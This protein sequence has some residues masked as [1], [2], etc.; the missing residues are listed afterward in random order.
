[1]L[2]W[3]FDRLPKGRGG[4]EVR[5]SVRARYDAAT[6]SEDNRRHWAHA[7]GLSAN[8]ANSPEVRRVLRNRARYETANNSYARG[9]VLTL[10][11]DVVGTGPRLQ[12]LTEDGEAN[13]R[14]EQA[15]MTWSKAIRLA[16]KLRTMRSARATDGEAFAILINNPAL[17]T[18]IQLD[19]RLVEAE[20]VATPDLVRPT[21]QAID[22]IEFDAAG[23]PTAY[24]VL[25]HHPGDGAAALQRDYDRIPAAAVLHWFRVDR[26]GQARGIPDIMP[27][28]PLFAQLRRFTLAVLAAAETAADFAG[29]LYT[30]APANGEADAAEPFEPIELEK[31]ALLTMPGG[32]KMSQM[33]AEQPATTYAEFKHELLNEIARCL[34]M[35]YN[36]AAANSSGYNYASGRLDHQT[37]FKAIRVEQSHLEGVVLDRLLAAWFDEAALLPDLLPAG[38]GP[39]AEWP[40]QWFWD[41]HEHV[42]PNPRL[43]Q[44]GNTRGGLQDRQAAPDGSHRRDA[45][46]PVRGQAGRVRRDRGRLQ[47]GAR[48]GA[49]VPASCEGRRSGDAGAVR[50]RGDR[51]GLGAGPCGPRRVDRRGEGPASRKGREAAHEGTCAGLCQRR[52]PAPERAGRDRRTMAES[53]RAHG[54][55]ALGEQ[56]RLEVRLT[57]RRSPVPRRSGTFGAGPFFSFPRTSWTTSWN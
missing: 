23:N 38:L 18:P 31:R 46:T 45:R 47:D 40:H 52:R 37:Y 4:R 43:C 35:P 34:N 28:L 49:E 50:A 16:E 27:A 21:G 6:T 9:I 22:G 8:G 55:R 13:R 36:V 26:P 51:S 33:Q 17:T 41:G 1:M 19:L 24:H 25:R 20:Q 15:F 42:D 39:I 54:T 12:L 14:I 57:P 53:R 10:A 29:I 32:W 5:R 2:K 3:L 44:T 30:D 48:P 7:D 11:H 56:A